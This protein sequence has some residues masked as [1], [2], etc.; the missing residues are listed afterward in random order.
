MKNSMDPDQLA[1]SE[2]SWSG[3]TPFSKEGMEFWKKLYPQWAYQ[4]K[5]SLQTF[6]GHLIS[7]TAKFH[8][9]S[10]PLYC[11]PFK[12]SLILT[13]TAHQLDHRLLVVCYLQTFFHSLFLHFKATKNSQE[14]KHA[15][16]EKEYHMSCSFHV[17]Y[18]ITWHKSFITWMNTIL[19][20]EPQQNQHVHK[21]FYALTCRLLFGAHWDWTAIPHAILLKYSMQSLLAWLRA[22][23]LENID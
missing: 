20:A 21:F 15:Y 13:E 3:S 22:L 2:A 18:M 4:A 11:F 14:P 23:N 6:L 8:L 12:R 7:L 1:S 5:P 9:N 16:K 10:G 19:G 17:I